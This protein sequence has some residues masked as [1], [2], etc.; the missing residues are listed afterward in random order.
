MSKMPPWFQQISSYH[1]KES[2]LPTS[3][4]IQLSTISTDYTPRVRTVV[5]RGWTD[6]YK[7]KIF[8]DRRSLKI[9]E[10]K[11]NNNVEI[12]WYFQK[13]R[14]QFRLRGIASMDFGKDYITSWDNLNAEAKSTWGWKTPGSKYIYD[15][16]NLIPDS[17]NS[18]LIDNF[19][20][21][22]IEIFHVDQ[23]LLSKPNQFRKR[24]ILNK[25]WDEER[26]NP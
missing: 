7:M 19:I 14:C 18:E 26:I 6:S 21:L 16:N 22:K 17:Q 5:F 8:T 23:L 24:W 9:N 3:K 25:Q 10:L 11:F 15:K 20:L 12:C 1:K 4:Y 2:K 13:S